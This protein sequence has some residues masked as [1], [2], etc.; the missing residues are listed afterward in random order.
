MRD[1]VRAFLTECTGL[2]LDLGCGEG[3]MIPMLPAGMLG[4]GLDQQLALA[5]SA[6][7]VLGDAGKLPFGRH[8]L[9][10]VLAL[11]LLEQGGL[12]SAQIL[13][14][15]RRVL[16]PGGRLLIR[17]PAHPWLFGPHD[18]NW[19]GA[20]RYRKAE[21]ADLVRDASFTIRR[22]SYANTLLFP[23]S[24][25]FRLGARW[26]CWGCGKINTIPY[27]VDR[28]LLQILRWEARW[29]R[30]RDLPMGLS[31]ICLAEA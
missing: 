2:V 7:F 15:T 25:L 26:G 5:V 16:K 30:Q 1:V 21:L 10:F 6:P 29:L 4:F 24:A 12:E 8:R 11:D 22:L 14:E 3:W 18:L 20:R 28:M 13:R 19:G 27:P 23:L 17:V 31:L 9:D